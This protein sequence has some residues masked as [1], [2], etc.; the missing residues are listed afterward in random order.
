ME[1]ICM[2]EFTDEFME[3]LEQ[4]EL[5]AELSQLIHDGMKEYTDLIEVAEVQKKYFDQRNKVVDNK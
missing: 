2:I 3:E 1:V 4:M 5:E